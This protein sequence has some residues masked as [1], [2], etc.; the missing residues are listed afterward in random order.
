MFPDPVDRC[1]LLTTELIL[2]FLQL[3]SDKKKKLN[4]SSSLI[5]LQQLGDWLQYYTNIQSINQCSFY[6]HSETGMQERIVM[7]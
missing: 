2:R 6:T 7:G 5:L 3:S 1:I 4:K